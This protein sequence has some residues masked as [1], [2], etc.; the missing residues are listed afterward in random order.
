LG[1]RRRGEREHQ[2]AAD[3]QHT[4]HGSASPLRSAKPEHSIN[5]KRFT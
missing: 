1:R 2:N 4:N 5:A 3:Y